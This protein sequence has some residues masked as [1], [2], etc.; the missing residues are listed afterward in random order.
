MRRY[1]DPHNIPSLL[2][3]LCLPR[4]SA[5]LWL[6]TEGIK[7]FSIDDLSEGQKISVFGSQRFS[8]SSWDFGWSKLSPFFGTRIF[9]PIGSNGFPLAT[10]RS[11]AIA[12]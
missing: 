7:F 10:S 1:E 6:P 12:R 5:T 9:I 11:A 2:G 4:V 3:V 8:Q